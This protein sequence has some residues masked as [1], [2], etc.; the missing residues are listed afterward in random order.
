MN[1]PKVILLSKH[2]PS[3]RR[4]LASTVSLINSLRYVAPWVVVAVFFGALAFVVYNFGD[5]S[6]QL[7]KTSPIRPSE[8]FIGSTS[9]Q[10]GT[11]SSIER[12]EIVRGGISKC[13]WV[14]HTCLVD[15]DTGWQSRRKWRLTNIDAPELGHSKCAREREIGERSLARLVELMSSGYRIHWSGEDDRYGR[16]LVSVELADGRDIGSVLMS[17]GLAQPWPNSGNIWCE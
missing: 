14:R 10:S 8:P 5:S 12:S 11:A 1:D 6:A 17:E 15:G 7:E 3:W 16:A 4:H 13:G 2:K 9:E